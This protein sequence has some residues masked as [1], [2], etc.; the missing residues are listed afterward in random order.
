MSLLFIFGAGASFGSDNQKTPP[1]TIKLYSS[2]VDFDKNKC[3]FP[4]K[5][6]WSNIPEELI[7]LFEYDFEKGMENYINRY[8]G[9]ITPLKRQMGLFFF[10]FTYNK[11]TN[12]YV[13][14]VKRL[15]MHKPSFITL[16]YDKLL[17]S[18]LHENGFRIS[19]QPFIQVHQG[20]ELC[21]PHGNCTFFCEGAFKS[22]PGTIFKNVRTSGRLKII[23]EGAEYYKRIMTDEQPP[24]ISYLEPNKMSPFGYNIIESQRS[25]YRTLI[26]SASVI[27]IIG[28]KLR[29]YENHIWKPIKESKA[30]LIYCSGKKSGKIFDEWLDFYKIGENRS[31]MN[32][33]WK[34]NYERICE[35]IGI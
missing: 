14:L 35:E 6:G 9:K 17:P 27:V 4:N 3:T 21:F 25:R 2:L 7:S 23:S 34:D 1:L 19:I 18:A 24:V 10:N 13:K 31:I 26:E 29:E 33:Y 22:V 8:P 32:G 30:D 28:L 11:D 16:N 15:K 5:T 12:L 20:T